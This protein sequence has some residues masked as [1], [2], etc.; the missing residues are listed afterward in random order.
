M[1]SRSKRAIGAAE[2]F[3]SGVDILF[4]INYKNKFKLVAK[5]MNS[6]DEILDLLSDQKISSKIH[7]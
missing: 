4:D 3:F 1:I 7:I 5:L 6:P 2:S